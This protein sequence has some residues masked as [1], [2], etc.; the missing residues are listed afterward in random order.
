MAGGS[1][2]DEL[3]EALERAPVP[4]HLGGGAARGAEPGG[5]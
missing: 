5:R 4:D 2:L 1:D 3:G